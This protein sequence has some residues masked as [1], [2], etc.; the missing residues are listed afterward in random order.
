MLERLLLMHKIEKRHYFAM[1]LGFAYSLIGIITAFF[2]FKDFMSLASIFLTTL[3]LVPTLI[4]YL[5]KE[6]KIEREE[7]LKHF[8]R[9]HKDVFETYL[10]IFHG[11]FLGFL[12][13]GFFA[14]NVNYD[15]SAYQFDFLKARGITPD[16]VSV[17]PDSTIGQV[18]NIIGRNLTVNV[19]AFF[20]SIA[21]GAGAIFLIV[22]NASI[23]ASFIVLLVRYLSTTTA[24]ATAI[25]ATMLIHLVPEI[26]GFLLAAIAGGVISR[27]L[28]RERIGSL[29]FRNVIKDA[30][31]MFL[32]SI[33]LIV[34]A[35]F[36]E[37]YVTRGVFRLF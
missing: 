9:N 23:F 1:L 3:L 34:L 36:L 15:V 35:A 18:V 10:F 29:A 22:Y 30:T 2:L 20:L 11:V 31:V 28:M 27:A 32:L 24:H 17:V 26:S 21:Y 4:Y 7:G 25:F 37:I 16:G 33:V 14:L 6:E 19:V 8:F 5:G 12:L 13:I